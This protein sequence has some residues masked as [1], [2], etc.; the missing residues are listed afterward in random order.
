[1]KNKIRREILYGKLKSEKCQE[2]L[3]RRL[4]AKQLPPE[5]RFVQVPKTIENT[6]T[7]DPQEIDNQN[8]EE[9]Q[10]LMQTDE[11]AS[12]FNQPPVYTP[13]VLITSSRESTAETFSFIEALEDLIPNST[14]IKRGSSH[15]VKEIVE[16][17]VERSYSDIVIV[18]ESNKRPGISQ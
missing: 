8:D 5:E 7:H 16:G 17:A 3:K 18:G 12:F 13:K 9:I 1:M 4:Q 2:K 14:Y 15:L 11:F 6:K 10:D